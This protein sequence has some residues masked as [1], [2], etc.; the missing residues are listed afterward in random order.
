VEADSLRVD[1]QTRAV[2]AEIASFLDSQGVEAYVVG[3]F[4]RD[5]LLGRESHD[6]DVA[7][8]ADP[9]SVGRQLADALAGRRKMD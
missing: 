8:V 4:L 5:A 1:S 3:G 9:L 7:V 6:V 2:L